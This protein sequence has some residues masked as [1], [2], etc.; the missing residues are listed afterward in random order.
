MERTAI[1][2]VA[3]CDRRVCADHSGDGRAP[4][5]MDL[6]SIL[7]GEQ[8]NFQNTS[9]AGAFASDLPLLNSTTSRER[10]WGFDAAP[11]LVPAGLL[12]MQGRQLGMPR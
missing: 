3:A 6:F 1:V 9:F 12:A 11:N 7:S 8:R 2:T 5:A 4:D 10:I